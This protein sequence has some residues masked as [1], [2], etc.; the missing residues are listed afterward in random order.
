MGFAAGGRLRGVYDVAKARAKK[1]WVVRFVQTFHGDWK[2]VIESVTLGRL[3]D[4]DGFVDRN[5]AQDSARSVLRSH[6]ILEL[7]EIVDW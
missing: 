3:C 6:G 1:P 4:A 2:Y 5:N 7:T